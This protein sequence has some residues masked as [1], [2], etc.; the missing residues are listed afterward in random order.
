MDDELTSQQHRVLEIATLL[1]AGRHGGDTHYVSNIAGGIAV[2]SAMDL[3]E[4]VKTNV[5]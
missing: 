3:I 4:I 5:E 1:L 2:K